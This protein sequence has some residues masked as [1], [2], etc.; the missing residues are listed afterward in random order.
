MDIGPGFANA[1]SDRGDVVGQGEFVVDGRTVRRAFLW[2][3]A[4]GIVNL[5]TVVGDDSMAVAVNNRRQV[6]GWSGTEATADIR[7]TMWVLSRHCRRT[8]HTA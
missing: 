6:V 5:G 4:D 7:A 8:S 3:A 1:V 2:N